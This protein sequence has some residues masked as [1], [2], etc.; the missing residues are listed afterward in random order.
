MNL[1]RKKQ[2]VISQNKLNKKGIFGSKEIINIIYLKWN[3]T[4]NNFKKHE[5]FLIN[6]SIGKIGNGRYVTLDE[7]KDYV[8]RKKKH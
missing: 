6:W 3:S 4:N 1:T 8:K 2:L 5:E 7:I